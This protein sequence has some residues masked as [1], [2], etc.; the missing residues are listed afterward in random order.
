[1]S[2]NSADDEMSSCHGA[3]RIWNQIDKYR[4]KLVIDQLATVIS[5]ENVYS[6]KKNQL[7]I[8]EVP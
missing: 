8:N 6:M 7:S 1:M 2:G 4:N 5:I 3:P